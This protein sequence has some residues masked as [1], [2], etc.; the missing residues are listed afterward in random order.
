MWDE[1]HP[2]QTAAN[3]GGWV[4]SGL[5]VPSTG[6]RFPW[7]VGSRPTSLATAEEVLPGCDLRAAAAL[8]YSNGGFMAGT[9]LK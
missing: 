8:C 4:Q 1:L 9:C 5:G 7:D 6:T 2:S 3:P